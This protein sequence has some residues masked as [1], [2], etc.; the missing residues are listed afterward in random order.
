M[1]AITLP[2]W[3]GS[4]SQASGSTP[5]G[6]YD[7]DVKFQNDA[8]RFAKWAAFRL[9]YPVMDVELQDVNFYAAYE[10]A[11]NEYGY[12]VNIWN[13]QQ[14]MLRLQGSPTNNNL[15]QKNA[16]FSMGGI[17]R[18]AEQYGQE[19]LVG[20]NVPLRHAAFITTSSVSVYDMFKAINVFRAQFDSASVPAAPSTIYGGTVT[21]S[22]WS[23]V[24]LD[25]TLSTSVANGELWIY[26][27]P[28]GVSPFNAPDNL[29]TFN[30][31]T[32]ASGSGTGSN[33][34]ISGSFP[35]YN[36]TDGNGNINLVFSASSTAFT[37]SQSVAVT[38]SVNYN[39]KRFQPP[40]GN[41]S[42]I[43]IKRVWHYSPPAIVRYFD[44]FAGTGM[45]TY[46]MLQEFG[47]TN[48]SVATSFMM[49]PI[50]ADLLRI[51]AIDFND[52]VR[53]SAYAFEVINKQIRIL[54]VPQD[55]YA[56]WFDYI[57]KS[58]RDDPVANAG[59]ADSAEFNG[60]SD[61][62][63]A[64]Y[65]NMVYSNINSIGLQWIRDYGL[66]IAKITL[67]RVRVKFN[68]LPIPNNE[69][70]LDGNDLITTGDNDKN[71]LIESLRAMLEKFT[72]QAQLEMEAAESE[73]LKKTLS[74][75][76]IPIY[77]G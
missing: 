10:E 17:I 42:E 13:A 46:S 32:I 2:I 57:L 50:Y 33:V 35:L 77:I 28:T 43:E 31:N 64:P 26:S 60:V 22:L 45:G 74:S 52:T 54:P 23:Q 16:N 30:L 6:F 56:I 71:A 72:K 73:A 9:G 65:Q 25:P 24:N 1:C 15:T 47:W 14:N 55:S 38:A 41:A 51:Q 11:I 29:L 5:Y 37:P 7:N 68:T 76:P 58:D 36:F 48:Y 12:E 18:I 20:G 21:S 19:V 59:G 39:T 75:I 34:P 49:L 69:T 44:P 3:P 40:I 63:N 27:T 70:T 53:K 67:G 62:S 61:M 4:G 8:P 66:A